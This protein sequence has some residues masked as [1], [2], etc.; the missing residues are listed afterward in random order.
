M[1][2]SY[3]GLYADKRHELLQAVRFCELNLIV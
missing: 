2:D 3:Q 1:I